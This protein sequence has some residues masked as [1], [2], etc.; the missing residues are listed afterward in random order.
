MNKTLMFIQ[1]DMHRAIND[2]RTSIEVN[3]L[4]LKELI[5]AVC[6]AEA[7]ETVE[8]CGH[9]FGWIRPDQLKRMREGQTRYC[10]IR[11]KK[12][13]EYCDPVY[14]DPLGYKPLDVVAKIEQDTQASD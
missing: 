4:D 12:N 14:C 9:I 10:S 5:A 3:V 2:K 7:R 11:R 1:A 6:A 8:K 13:D